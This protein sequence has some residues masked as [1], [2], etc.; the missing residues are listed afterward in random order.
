[1]RYIF[2]IIVFAISLTASPIYAGPEDQEQ[3]D[4]CILE[5]LKNAKLDLATQL[6]KEACREIHKNP[7]LLSHK[8]RDYNECLLE[9]LPG[10]QS[11]DAVLEIQSACKRK[12]LY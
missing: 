3:Y 11:G 5:H 2:V 4:D 12:H 6:I 1:M 9:Y 10:I 7:G 8:R